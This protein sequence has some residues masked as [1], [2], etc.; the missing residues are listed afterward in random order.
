[1]EW[2]IREEKRMHCTG[3]CVNRR[4]WGAKR[5]DGRER[6]VRIATKG[7]DIEREVKGAKRA[8]MWRRKWKWRKAEIP[9]RE[10]FITFH[11]VTT[12]ITRTSGQNVRS[13][14]GKL[15]TIKTKTSTAVKTTISIFFTIGRFF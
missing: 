13:D 15:M 7:F 14:K 4:E 10:I 3:I 11:G 1:M 2:N 9:S 12:V 8:V 5:R 6:E